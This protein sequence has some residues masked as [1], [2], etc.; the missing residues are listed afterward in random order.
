M[1]KAKRLLKDHFGY[2]KFRNLQEEII[3][4]IV[5]GNDVLAVM[6]TGGGKSICYQ[7]PALILDGITIVISPLISLMKDQVDSIKENGIEA[8][9]INSSVN[10]LSI[11][12]ILLRVKE[13]NIKILYVAPE[14]LKSMEFLNEIA[15]IKVSQVAVDE[16]HC[17]S[18]WGHDFRTSYRD[19]KGFIEFLK[20]RPVVTAFTATATKEVRKD[21]IKL[22]NLNNPKVFISGFDR[23]NLYINV[24]K[25]SNKDKYVL[26][27]VEKNKDVSGIIYALTRK[28]VESI[29]LK[30]NKKGYK[31]AK[32]HGGMNPEERNKNQE[33]FVYDRVNII[34][35]TNAFGMGIDKSD[36][37][38]IIHYNMPQNIEGYYQEI[39]RAGRDNEKSECIL[40]F[41]SQDL[42]TIRYLIENSTVD[43]NR[44]NNQYKKMQDM[45]DF[46]YTNNC[47]RKYLLNYFGETLEDDCNNCS[48]C[49]SSAEVKDK[50]IDA[51]KVISCIYRMKRSFGTNMI[52]DVLRGSK[53]AK[54]I[55][56]GFH[57]LSTYG[58]MKEYSKIDLRD[59][60][61]TLVAQGF[62]SLVEGEFPVVSLNNR[63][64]NV[65]KG[66]EKVFLKIEEKIDKVFQANGL[67]EVLRNTRVDI[68]RE[69]NVPPYIIFSDKALLE[70][71]NRYPKNKKEFLDISGV[72]KLKEEKYGE[73]FI[74]VILQY[75]KDNGINKE[76]IFNEYSD[77]KSYADDYKGELKVNSDKKLLDKLFIMREEAALKKNILPSSLIPLRSL[78]EISARYPKTI[79]ELND[80]SMI[81]PAKIKV[82]GE[83]VINEVNNYL[84]ENNIE[85]EFVFKGKEC[86]IVDG[87]RRKNNEI[88]IDELKSGKTLEE[89]SKEIEISVSTIM[90]YVLDY[91]KDGNN[92]DFNFDYSMYYKSEYDSEIKKAIDEIGYE[93]V[94]LINKKVSD[95][96]KYENIRA[97]IFKNILGI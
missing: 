35:A 65:I 9:Y 5:N 75:M 24:I 13:G 4:E 58:I 16:A 93:K 28:E 12:N 85:S 36:I 53:N 84:A 79:E 83:I 31:V 32:Y 56:F 27:F 42:I 76:F 51:Q 95:E 80:I 60:I 45:V 41:S 96:I 11:K 87:E 2:D 34:V 68:A 92:I 23:E 20:K 67:Y 48:N 73:K 54:I 71:S 3:N 40:L 81:G 90:G 62:L 19:I 1:E 14:R 22:L 63:S 91:L 77:N 39:G 86:V 25:G 55:K 69:E 44:K 88:A 38:F 70:M 78:K 94:S 43:V 97:Y 17:I 74:N 49:S 61:N 8:A 52:V 33:D 59:F 10:S 29:Y 64:I 50:T 57:E 66:Q 46:V 6:P 37:R 7:I 26:N 18:A 47:Y 72:G 89:I 30:L 82:V 15:K 21:I